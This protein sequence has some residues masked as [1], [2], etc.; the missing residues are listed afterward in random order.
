M[1]YGTDVPRWWIPDFNITHKRNLKEAESSGKSKTNEVSTSTI[2][3]RDNSDLRSKEV[4]DLERMW[5][6]KQ[7]SESVFRR[8]RRKSYTTSHRYAEKRRLREAVRNEKLER[9]RRDIHAIQAVL[10]ASLALIGFLSSG[11][12]GLIIG[13]AI[14]VILIRLIVVFF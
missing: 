9:L 3:D 6:G 10:A 12:V 11:Y 5:A 4:S 7:T 8:S 1:E 13:A 14:G 2:L